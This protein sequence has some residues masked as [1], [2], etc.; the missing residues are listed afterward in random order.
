MLQ[1][2][3]WDGANGLVACAV[4]DLRTYSKPTTAYPTAASASIVDQ[5]GFPNS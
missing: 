2:L 4:F 1:K 5:W 3:V